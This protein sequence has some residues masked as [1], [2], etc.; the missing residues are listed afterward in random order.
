MP[1]HYAD[2]TRNPDTMTADERRDEVAGILARGLVRALEAKH[3]ADIGDRENLDS[4]SPLHLGR[5]GR[6]Q[7][8]CAGARGRWSGVRRMPRGGSKVHAANGGELCRGSVH[9]PLPARLCPRA[10]CVIEYGTVP[11][12]SGLARSG[13]DDSL[14]R[15]R[16]AVPCPAAFGATTCRRCGG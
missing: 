1:K 3:A 13:G 4:G 6:D 8:G 7:D 11:P 9:R 14:V 10:G 16:A 2:T 12:W 15:R 5:G